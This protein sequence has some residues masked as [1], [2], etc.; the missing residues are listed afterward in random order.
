[1]ILLIDV[2]N[3]E[4]KFT[5]TTN[6]EVEKVFRISTNKQ[7]TTDELLLDI[8]K[9][10]KDNDIDNVVIS[11]VVPRITSLLDMGL[12]N[13]YNIKPIIVKAGVKTTLKINTD[14]PNEVGSDLVVGAVGATTISDKN[15]II[16]DLG[17]AIKFVYL[18]GKTLEGV[19]ISPGVDMGLRALSSDTALLPDTFIEV[20]KNVLGTNTQNCIQ[21]GLTYGVAAQIDGLVDRIKE[22]TSDNDMDIIITG[23]ISPIIKP[24]C[25]T[26]LILDEHLLFKGL[27]K[28]YTLN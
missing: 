25:K 16:I 7:Y 13:K 4:I 9:H 15:C 21:S 17:T 5:K 10:I 6:G 2:G 11:S 27:Y 20:P 3:T 22:M 1:M 12:K 14:N 19:I 24:L 26:Q 18:K 28:I 23:G 8:F